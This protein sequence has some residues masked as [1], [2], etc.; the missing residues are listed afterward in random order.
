MKHFGIIS[1]PVAGHLDP[2]CA[3]GRELTGRGHRVT[4]FHMADVGPKV[5][6]ERLEFAVIGHIDHP[7]GTLPRTLGT[8]GKLSGVSAMRYT[9]Q[10]AARSSEMFLRDLPGA[11]KASKVNVLLVD[12]MEPGGASVA[13][14]MRLPYVTVCNAL[15][16]NRDELTPPP[17]TNFRFADTRFARI[18]NRLGY[19]VGKR[20]VDPITTTTNRYRKRWRLPEYQQPD[21]S[22]STLAQLSQQPP[23]FD[24]P[25]TSIPPV[26]HYLGPFRDSFCKTSDFPWERLNGK[27]LVY[28]SLGSMQGSKVQLL[29]RF[30]AACSEA[31]VQAVIS[32]GGALSSE[33]AEALPGGHV[34][35][36]YAPQRE[37][38]GRAQATL[39]HAG[40]NTVLD[41]LSFGV[42]L[43]A[44][45][46]TYEQPGI[47]RRIEWCSV[48]RTIA[49]RSA[50]VPAVHEALTD[51]LKSQTYRDAAGLVQ[52]SIQQAGGS[53]RAADI[54][55]QVT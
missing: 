50:D 18:R 27:P 36:S 16:L 38:I 41:S 34:V 19:A 37:V 17:F 30:A 4:V 40:L 32:H 48:G 46:I 47:A 26:F 2:F 31:D 6:R 29:S 12:Q 21:D 8:I 51:V 1:P 44:V 20:A 53:R 35:V 9:V 49:M 43:V 24:F 14:Y 55:E 25:R 22:F 39:T 54:I 33:V 3:I 10:A 5:L 11:L 45:P 13:D 42:P 52:R 23:A 28:A 15:V 7:V